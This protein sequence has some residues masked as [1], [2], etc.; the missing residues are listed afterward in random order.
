MFMNTAPVM[1]LMKLLFAN[2][3]HFSDGDDGNLSQQ[4]ADNTDSITK[5][6]QYQVSI[7]INSFVFSCHETI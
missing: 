2:L 7:V 6:L 4:G 5:M 1:T 3:L